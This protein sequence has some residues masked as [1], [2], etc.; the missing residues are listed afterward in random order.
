MNTART[1]ACQG[2]YHGHGKPMTKAMSRQESIG[3]V[4]DAP[5][6][7]YLSDERSARL[8]RQP[9]RPAHHPIEVLQSMHDSDELFA[10][11]AQFGGE[12]TPPH[13]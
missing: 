1:A 7:G 4:M 13:R 9:P 3:K 12:L 6:R 11:N 5:T 10:A 2:Q 8:K